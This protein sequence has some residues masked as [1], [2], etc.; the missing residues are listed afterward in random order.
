MRL[1]GTVKEFQRFLRVNGLTFACAESCTGGLL[2]RQM[3]QPAGSSDVFWGGV[4]SYSNEAKQ[5][6]LK[7]PA[8]VL[9]AHGAV[10][11]EVAEAMVRGLADI[12]GVGLAV[13]ITGIA[14]P[15][16]GSDAKP[17]G[18]VWFGLASVRGG[19]GCAVAVR[20]RFR[21]SRARIQ[22]EAAR[23][24]RILALRWWDSDG[25]LD[26]LQSLTDN[27]HKSF[28]EASQTPLSFPIN[29]F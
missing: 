26:S 14:G 11:G 13:S 20:H 6:F 21:G 23:W 4:V 10:S 28:I 5:R 24:S 3:T 29:P 16:G 2:A 17:V 22:R 15:G 25:E 19:A 8:A 7:V 18:T 27:N 1:Q 12:A 9:D